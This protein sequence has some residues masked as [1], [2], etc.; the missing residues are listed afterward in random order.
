MFESL[1]NYF[2]P[3]VPNRTITEI[4]SFCQILFIDDNQFDV[5][6]ILRDAGWNNT[7]QIFDI[8]SLDSSDITNAHILFVDIQGVGVALKFKNE[9]LGLI[10]ALKKKYPTKQVIIYSAEK[11]G[12]RFH[13]S[14]SLADARLFKNA[15]PFEFQSLVEKYAK[16]S[17]SLRECVKR[18]KKA[19]EIESGSIIS[20]DKIEK[21]LKS[22][23][24]K[25]VFHEGYVGKLFNL[26]NAA[27]L[28]TIISTFFRPQS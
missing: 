7:K 15:D 4:K 17:F 23:A 1:I 20:E 11:H 24:R 13:E 14:L 22:I 16:E 2:K 19:Y 28:S 9:G 5:V 26:Q 8:D 27:N 6:E 12:D 21:H 3:H 18:L 25:G 10:K